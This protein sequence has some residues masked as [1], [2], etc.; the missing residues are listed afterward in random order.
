MVSS[1][2]GCTVKFDA[3]AFDE[4]LDFALKNKIPFRPRYI[5]RESEKR[6]IQ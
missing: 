2:I 1:I 4:L 5:M 6:W 3:D